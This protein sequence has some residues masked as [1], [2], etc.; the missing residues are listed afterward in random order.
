[1]DNLTQE[2]RSALMSRIKGRDTAPELFVRRLIHAL[3]YRF[4]LHAGKLPGRPD[5]VFP[6][7][8]K[9][10]FVHG[11]FWHQHDCSKGKRPSSNTEFWLRKLEGNIR[12][13]EAAMLALRKLGWD[14][15]VV[16]ECEIKKP[17]NLVD[18]LQCFLG[19]PGR[20]YQLPR[21]RRASSR[22]QNSRKSQC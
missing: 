10:I 7:R 2:E 3:G 22:P 16:W 15:Y 13:D 20:C 19:P 12:R 18:R 11:C 17:S 21:Q 5:I 6:A 8:R 4:R 1:M 9:A 14:A